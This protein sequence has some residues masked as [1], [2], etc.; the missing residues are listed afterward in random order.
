MCA[1]VDV[2]PECSISFIPQ[3][4]DIYSLLLIK[5][6]ADSIKEKYDIDDYFIIVSFSKDR[7]VDRLK[8]C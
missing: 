4:Y 5:G 8:R 6:H 1:F 2:T 3:Q 7:F